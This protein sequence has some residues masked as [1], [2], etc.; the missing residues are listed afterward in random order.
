MFD[1]LNCKSVS[2]CF[3]KSFELYIIECG[4]YIKSLKRTNKCVS[5]RYNSSYYIKRFK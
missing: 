5:D 2:T 4:N 3:S 1:L